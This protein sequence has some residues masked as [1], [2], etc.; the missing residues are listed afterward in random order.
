MEVQLELLKANLI[1]LQISSA[2][3]NFF[4]PLMNDEQ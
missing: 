3:L 1:S 2:R 4:D